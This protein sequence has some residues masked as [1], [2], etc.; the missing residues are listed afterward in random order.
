MRLVPAPLVMH[1]TS[2]HLCAL[3]DTV[4]CGLLLPASFLN[5]V[6]QLVAATSSVLFGGRSSLLL[7]HFLD[8]A[9]LDFR[10]LLGVDLRR[11][12]LVSTLCSWVFL[13]WALWG[14]FWGLLLLC[15]YFVF[16]PFYVIMFSVCW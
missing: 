12:L 14:Y 1:T 10:Q 3:V 16:G 11:W 6:L 4:A 8:T 2:F 15:A 13:F 5:L 7:F 9:R